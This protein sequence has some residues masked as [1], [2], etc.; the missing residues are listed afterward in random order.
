MDARLQRLFL[1]PECRHMTAPELAVAIR[2]ESITVTP[3]TPLEWVTVCP[4]PHR[5]FSRAGLARIRRSRRELRKLP[6]GRSRHGCALRVPPAA[7]TYVRSRTP[8]N[9]NAA[10]RTVRMGAALARPG[11]YHV[12]RERRHQEHPCR[13]DQQARDHHATAAVAAAP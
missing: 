5:A 12:R 7:T 11:D 4:S 3:Y 6:T 9:S 2:R 8:G 13:A 10:G 1:Q